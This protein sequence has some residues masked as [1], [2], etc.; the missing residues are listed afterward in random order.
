MTSSKIHDKNEVVKGA[1]KIFGGSSIRL[2]CLN[3]KYSYNLYI[4][5]IMVYLQYLH[6][7]KMALSM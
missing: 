3:L 4:I 5:I 2:Y 1:N 6:K 7:Y